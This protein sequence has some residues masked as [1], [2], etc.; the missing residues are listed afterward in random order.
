MTLITKLTVAPASAV[1]KMVN[2]FLKTILA[3][4]NWPRS[5][6]HR[7]YRKRRPPRPLH[8]QRTYVTSTATDIFQ[9]LQLA[10]QRTRDRRGG[11]EKTC[12]RDDSPRALAP[13][14]TS[15]IADR[16][17]GKA[18]WKPLT[19]DTALCAA[20]RGVNGS[21]TDLPE[22]PC[23][24]DRWRRSESRFHNVCFPKSWLLGQVAAPADMAR[25][26]R[27]RGATAARRPPRRRGRGGACAPRTPAPSI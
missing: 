25:R 15:E 11:H 26:V 5:S 1:Y 3:C 23:G 24:C 16:Y 18:H 6:A 20:R 21:A 13:P 17:P 19:L 4:C 8:Y 7:T 22:S 12:R 2:V 14:T 10:H 27:F 9:N